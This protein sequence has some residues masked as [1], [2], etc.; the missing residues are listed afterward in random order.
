MD[1]DFLTQ[2]GPD[3]DLVE[4]KLRTLVA[5]SIDII[6]D[7]YVDLVQ[8]GGKRLR[9]VLYLLCAGKSPDKEQRTSIAAAL[10]FIHMATLVHDDIVDHAE[11]RRGLPATH[12]V[13]GRHS[14][15]LA[16]DYLFARAFFI[17]SQVLKIDSREDNQLFSL[18]T[19]LVCVICEGEFLQNEAAFDL[20][21]SE[22][23]YLDII[24]RKTAHFFA[25]ACQMGAVSARYDEQT[26]KGLRR[27]GYYLGMAFQIRDDMLD[28][29]GTPEKIGKP[30]NH[31]LSQGNITL[32]VIY[33][34]KHVRDHRLRETI[35]AKNF[36]KE[37]FLLCAQLVMAAGGI[38]YSRTVMTQYVEAALA[39]IPENVPAATKN[40]L[41]S[42]AHELLSCSLALKLDSHSGN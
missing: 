25:T 16:G 2:I 15:V 23:R 5:S 10:E 1:E 13:W 32:P 21:M 40:A 3:L 12:T 34:L 26:V 37:K 41:R 33:A 9:P 8:S 22:E 19:Q 6:N 14:A 18:L 4:K 24:G 39:S 38:E 31:D 36:S 42:V 35:T 7:I 11:L 28:V 27:Y 20:S 17:L 30:V 29:I